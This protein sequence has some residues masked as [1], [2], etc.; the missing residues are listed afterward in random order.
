M[1]KEKKV[2]EEKKTTVL[3]KDPPGPQKLFPMRRQMNLIQIWNILKV[4]K[5]HGQDH[6]GNFAGTRTTESMWLR[7]WRTALRVGVASEFT[8]RSFSSMAMISP[9]SALALNLASFHLLHFQVT[10]KKAVDYIKRLPVLNML[11]ARKGVTQTWHKIIH[12]FPF[13]VLW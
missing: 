1:I 13:I 8:I 3:L 2:E 9:W 6:K 10:H 11:V 7:W 12:F 5:T 4:L